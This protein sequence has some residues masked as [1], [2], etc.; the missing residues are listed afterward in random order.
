MNK[1]EEQIL[2]SIGKALGSM[3][4]FQKGYLLGVAEAAAEKHEEKKQLAG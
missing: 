3:S 2:Q 4:E 1:Q